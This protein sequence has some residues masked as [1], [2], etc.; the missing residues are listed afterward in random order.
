MNEIDIEQLKVEIETVSARLRHARR[1]L[2][3][4]E[5]EFIQETCARMDHCA[6]QIAQLS[7]NV[8]A[9]MQPSLLAVL[10]EVDQTMKAFGD[11]LARKRQE[12]ASGNQGRAAGAAYRRTQN[13][14]L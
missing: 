14:N 6:G 9:R 4:D 5:D 1:S 3:Q 7:G 8:R 10:D 13:S 12:L 2:G 11:E